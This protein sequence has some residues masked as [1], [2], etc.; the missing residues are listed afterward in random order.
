MR[1]QAIE[2]VSVIDDVTTDICLELDGLQWWLPDDPQD[3][4]AYE[5][6]GHDIPFPGPIAH[7]NCSSTQIPVE[8]E[9][10]ALA[11]GALLETSSK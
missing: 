3:Y 10:G 8:S 1:G 7:W 4:E 9:E 2:W 5:P 6:I 11:A